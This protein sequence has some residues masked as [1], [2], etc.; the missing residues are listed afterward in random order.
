MP[1]TQTS[2]T[3]KFR[4]QL[5]IYRGSGTPSSNAGAMRGSWYFITLPKKTSGIIK[6]LTASTRRGW[7]SVRVTVT[8]GQTTWRTSIFPD[9]KAGAYLLPVKAA[10]REKEGIEDGDRIA[11]EVRTSPT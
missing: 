11:V 9:A 4:A 10:V 3:Y 1:A 7:G 6:G 5:W 8:I 2:H